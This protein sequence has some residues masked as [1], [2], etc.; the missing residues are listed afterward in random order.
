MTVLHCQVAPPVFPTDGIPATFIIA[1]DG[2]IVAA[3]VGSNDWDTPE[4]CGVPGEDR[5]HARRPHRGRGGAAFAG[6]SGS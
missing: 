4:G 5:R 3:E 2:R 6:G 1:P